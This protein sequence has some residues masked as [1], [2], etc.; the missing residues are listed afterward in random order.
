MKSR[1]SRC[2]REKKSVAMNKGVGSRHVCRDG[3]H[4]SVKESKGKG[5]DID[6]AKKDQ[7]CATTRNL[8]D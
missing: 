2:V 7:V 6:K 4:V 8:L 1:R 3:W 5:E